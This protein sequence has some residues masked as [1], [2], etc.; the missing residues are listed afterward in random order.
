MALSKTIETIHGFQALNAYHR[1]EA[2]SLI[3]KE[4]ISFHVRSYTATNK[5]F[6][7]EQVMTAPYQLDGENPIKQAYSYLKTHDQFIDS[8]DC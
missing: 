1:V 6:F 7:V 2:V 4:Q 3:N 5:P 8:K